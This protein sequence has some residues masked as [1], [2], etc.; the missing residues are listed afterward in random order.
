[1]LLPGLAH[2]AA[3]VAGQDPPACPCGHCRCCSWSRWLS[4]RSLG[5]SPDSWRYCTWARYCRRIGPVAACSHQRNTRGSIVAYADGSKHTPR[6]SRPGEALL[7]GMAALAAIVLLRQ[8]WLSYHPLPAAAPLPAGN[9]VAVV[10]PALNE[11][12]AVGRVVSG[13]PRAALS[14]MGYR[15]RVIVVDDGS[16]DDTGAVAR[17]AGADV[18]VR[19][20]TRQGVGAALRTGLTAAQHGGAGAVVYLDGDGEY[21]PC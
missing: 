12:A 15:V 1:M 5:C 17:A 18:V 21:G 4:G 19:H 2:I 9:W 8:W 7:F 11:A 3:G 20:E 10:I 6:A 13:V 14:A 16:T